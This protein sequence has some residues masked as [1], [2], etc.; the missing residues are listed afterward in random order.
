MLY[1]VKAVFCSVLCTA[2]LFSG[3]LVPIAFTTF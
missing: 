3:G 2:F 1:V